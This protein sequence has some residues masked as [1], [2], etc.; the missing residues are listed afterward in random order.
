MAT[1]IR[2]RGHAC[3]NGLSPTQFLRLVVS[4]RGLPHSRPLQTGTAPE[5]RGIKCQAGN[6]QLNQQ[7]RPIHIGAI[8]SCSHLRGK[9]GE[10]QNE[11][12]NLSARDN[13]PEPWPHAS[14]L[15]S[16]S[17]RDSGKR[18]SVTEKARAPTPSGYSPIAVILFVGERDSEP[19]WSNAR[20]ERELE[21]VKAAIAVDDGLFGLFLRD[22]WAALGVS[23]SSSSSWLSSSCSLSSLFIPLR[24]TLVNSNPAHSTFHAYVELVA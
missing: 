18:E 5:R 19:D 12:R 4:T 9:Q 7:C 1:V 8:S 2:D 23:F 10:Q 14:V 6:R 24:A 22:L 11:I 16:Q 17:T 15:A 3:N 13:T 20:E 21:G